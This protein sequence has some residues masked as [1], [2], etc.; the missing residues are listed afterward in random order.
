MAQGTAE[1]EVTLQRCRRIA[2]NAHEVRHKAEGSL[3]AVEKLPGFT[4]GG[5]GVDLMDA[6]H[7]I[8][9]WIVASIVLD[10]S[11]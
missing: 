2:D 3:D 11:S 6:V 4:G 10:E 8:F 9:G 1:V 7:R 5:G